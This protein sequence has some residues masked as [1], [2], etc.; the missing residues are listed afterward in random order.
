MSLSGFRLGDVRGRYPDEIN[1]NFVTDF[2]HAFA[3]HFNPKGRIAIG[4]DMRPSGRPLQ[5][6]LAETF[7]SIGFDV[8]DMG[9]CAT[10]LGYFASGLRDVGAAVI[11]TASH[12]PAGDNGLKC[13]LS[14]GHAIT[15]DT[16]LQEIEALM[17][18]GYRHTAGAGSI[19]QT[20]TKGQYVG[21]LDRLFDRANLI[22]APIALNGLNG[23]AA[24]VAGDIA[25]HFGLDTTWT[26]RTPG[27]MP[28]SGA[29]PTNPALV[30]EMQSFMAGGDFRLGVAWDGDC[31]RC[32]FYDEKGA[33]VPTYYIV[34]LLTEWFL[35]ANPGS[36]I[37]FDTK[38]CWNTLDIIER[39]Q[40]RP[41]PSKT[42][43]AFMK[44]QMQSIGAIYGGE[45]S[46]HHYFGHFFGCDS[47]MIAWLSVMELLNAQSRLLSELVEERRQQFCC[48]PEISIAL[49]DPDAA[50]EA[51]MQ[52]MA[53]RALSVERFDGIS[54]SMPG[55]WRF[56][57]RRS[58]TEPLV[59]VN[60]EARNSAD[61]LLA[62]GPAVFRI[63]EPYRA[64]EADWLS[65]FVIQ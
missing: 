49:E 37:V 18:E 22:Q 28:E 11:V 1:E 61:R 12:N 58:K 62:E 50:F 16:G 2:A 10:E 15:T 30:R 63:L 39:Y 5:Q 7:A 3:G 57:L 38:L 9:L 33:L 41:A 17:A 47:G 54:L 46:S 60:F 24:T 65:G 13:V 44:Q 20:D 32:A 59:R 14:E 27:P 48:T 6:A 8:L 56:S 42:G 19:A 52:Q 4:R 23:T 64:D 53:D 51:I 31:D 36:A 26:R 25:D 43:H 29:D 34:G 21:F 45:L 40:G 55:D 35:K